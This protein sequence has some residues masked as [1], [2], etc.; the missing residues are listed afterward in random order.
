MSLQ[1]GLSRLAA[2][3]KSSSWSPAS[4]AS[5]RLACTERSWVMADARAR[6]TMTAATHDET[7]DVVSRDYWWSLLQPPAQDA[8]L[9]LVIPTSVQGRQRN[10]RTASGTSARRGAARTVPNSGASGLPAR[11]RIPQIHGFGSRKELRQAGAVTTTMAL[12][13]AGPMTGR[14]KVG[15]RAR[16][17]SCRTLFRLAR[18]TVEFL[19]AAPSDDHRKCLRASRPI[20]LTPNLGFVHTRFG[21]W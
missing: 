9:T 5:A 12:L 16:C 6:G 21:A 18:C 1:P 19:F 13:V 4:T 2:W 8:T 15:H 17:A 11:S 14:G 20:P 3:T 10:G 7:G